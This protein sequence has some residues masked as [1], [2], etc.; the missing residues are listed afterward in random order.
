M[1]RNLALEL[2]RVTEAAALASAR[3]MGKGD[4]LAADLA[5]V[6]AMELAIQGVKIS[7]TVVIGDEN[8]EPGSPLYKGGKVGSGGEIELDL[9]I[10]PLESKGSLADGQ[11]NAISAIALGPKGSFYEYRKKYMDKIA[12][13]PGLAECI[14]LNSSVFD[15]LVNIAASRRVYVEDLTVSILDRPRHKKLIEEVRK[16]GARIELCRDGD[17]ASAIAAA[18][19]ETG[20]DVAMG[21]GHSRQGVIAAAALC[22]L[23]GGFQARFIRDDDTPEDDSSEDY[24]KVFGIGDLITGENIMFA[25]TGVS[26]SDFLEGV[27]FRQGGAVTH[28]LVLR[29][30]SGTVRFLKTEHFFEKDPDYT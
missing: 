30:K 29:G 7:G 1:D 28:S 22:C 18:L 2:V 4:P 5:A 11:S 17:I 24:D 26:H 8:C 19:P 25:V 14:D 15:N 27:M 3:H 10:D 16:A 12:V 13:G 6:A 20:I 21:T 23:G 9:V